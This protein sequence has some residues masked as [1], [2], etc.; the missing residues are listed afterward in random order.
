[1]AQERLTK[2]QRREQ[3]REIARLEREQRQKTQRRNG[4]LIR[5]GATVGIV[6]LLGAVGWGIWSGTRPA[7]PGP[8]NMASDGILLTGSEGAVTVAETPALAVDDEPHATDPSEYDVPV[9][10]VTYI[11]F[12]CPYCGLF[13]TTNGAQIRD[14]V[15]QGL[16][17]LEV[18]PINLLSTKFQGTR[19][20]ARSANASACVAAYEPDSFLDVNE[21]FFAQQPEESSKGLSN[22]EI[23]TLLAGAGVDSD[24]VTNCVNSES[25]KGWVDAA[26]TRALTG[27]LPNTEEERVTGTPTIL[28][29]GVRYGGALDDPQAFAAFVTQ[30]ADFSDPDATPT[31]TPTPTP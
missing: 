25:F 2:D 12:G 28:V 22:D 6:A 4:I 7:G 5:V 3:A 10:I 18:H 30:N 13:E 19:Y 21:A 17:T 14:M 11:D 20:S 29:N 16:A 23:L 1:M 24:E 9:H 26:T 15:A 31:P 27:P 8:A